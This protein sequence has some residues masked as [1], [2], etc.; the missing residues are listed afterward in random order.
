MLDADS[1]GFIGKHDMFGVLDE[2]K[3]SYWTVERVERIFEEADTGGDGAIDFD[4]FVQWVFQPGLEQKTFRKTVR[5]PLP[6]DK[7]VLNQNGGCAREVKNDRFISRQL[8]RFCQ[9]TLD[10]FPGALSEIKA[11]RKRSHWSWYFFP[12]PPYMVDGREVGSRKNQE[13]ALR[14]AAGSHSGDL[15]AQAFLRFE[16][17]GVSLRSM[18]FTMM[19]AVSEQLEK[20]ISADRLVGDID[21]PK[22]RS[23]LKLFERASCSEGDLEVNELC[24]RALRLMN[25]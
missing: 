21:E 1:D 5:L 3:P 10:K 12:V 7:M 14:D 20:G 19:S 9:V 15:A 4:E 11:G 22:L 17:D 16:A 24:R 2:L 18:Y 13:W 23:S 6:A 8:Q 25:P